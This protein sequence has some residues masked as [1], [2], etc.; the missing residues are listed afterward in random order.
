MNFAGL[1][2]VFGL[3]TFGQLIVVGMLLSEGRFQTKRGL[4]WALIPV[5]GPIVNFIKY[6]LY[7]ASLLD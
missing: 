7:E 6:I 3:E 1:G 2:I 5:V 4:Y